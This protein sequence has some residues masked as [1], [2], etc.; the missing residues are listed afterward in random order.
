MRQAPRPSTCGGPGSRRAQLV[1]AGVR[2][3]LLPA[4]VTRPLVLVPSV[5]VHDAEQTHRE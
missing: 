5:G 1:L 4:G 2:A 3:Q